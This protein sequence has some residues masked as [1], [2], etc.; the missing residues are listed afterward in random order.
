MGKLKEWKEAT[1]NNSK[2]IKFLG[3]NLTKGV[4]V[5]QGEKYK[6]L[7]KYIRKYQING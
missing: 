6:I 2:N 1:Y 4:R 7:W 3:L 5:L